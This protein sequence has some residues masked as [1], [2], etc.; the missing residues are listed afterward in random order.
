MIPVDG[1]YF[2]WNALLVDLYSGEKTNSSLRSRAADSHNKYNNNNDS[3]RQERF[4]T[5]FPATVESSYCF[6][7]KL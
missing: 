1:Y 7:W 3:N 6:F 2:N 5:V 4:S